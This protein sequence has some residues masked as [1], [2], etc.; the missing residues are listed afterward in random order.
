M[1]LWIIFAVMTAIGLWAILA[2]F[3]IK[4]GSS[5]AHA[6]A[7]DLAVYRD[8]LSELERETAAGLIDGQE[9]DGA[10]AEI[11]RRL[12]AAAARHD[13]LSGN[14]AKPENFT[15]VRRI[16]AWSA[17]IG[18]PAVGVVLYLLSGQPGLP[19][20]PHASRLKEPV[21]GQSMATLVARAEAHLRA[22][23]DDARG[24][25]ILAPAYNRL[26]RFGDAAYAL[27]QL[28]RIEG[29][30]P[31]I[32]ADYGEALTFVERGIVSKKAADAFKEALKLKAG[33]VKARY[34]LA[35]AAAQDGDR[36]AALE[37][38]RALL[39]T[40]PEKASWRALIEKAIASAV[41]Q[42]EK[43]KSGKKGGPPALS[44]DT[45]AAAK[46]MTAAQRQKM[47]KAMVARLAAR[48]ETQGDD[49]DG[50]LRLARS[51]SVLGDNE[52]ARAALANAARNFAG[53]AAAL[54]RI[55]DAAS[56][57]KPAK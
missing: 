15:R 44:R 55:R 33:L 20:K 39:K 31:G 23:P 50:W 10:R 26:G 40:A 17:A 43:S 51:Y 36:A 14:G 24:W 4:S 42:I 8:Q 22:K 3:R 57:L 45:L 56:R 49:L 11:S 5:A 52:A 25:R 29:R 6:A 48:L 28:M 21:A 13:E 30:K 41:V 34:Y 19:G 46:N 38:W 37:S 12:L 54:K 2:P 32:L 35:M 7:Q 53:K 1:S 9:A 16:A 27:E 47:I 18:V